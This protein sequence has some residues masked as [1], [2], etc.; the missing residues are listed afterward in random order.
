MALMALR[1]CR[2]SLEAVLLGF[3]VC[4]SPSA[5]ATAKDQE[6]ESWSLSFLTN[7]D[8]QK[9]VM[10]SSETWLVTY[11]DGGNSQSQAMTNIL[12]GLA[13]KH[14]NLGINLGMVDCAEETKLCRTAGIRE[15]IPVIHLLMGDPT[16]N[17]YTRKSYR[18]PIPFVGTQFDVRSLERFFSKNYPV[19]LVTTINSTAEFDAYLANNTAPSPL[20]S[21]PVAVL[22][23]E[24]DAVGMLIRT[25]SHHFRVRIKF[26]QLRI[27]K[28][29]DVASRYGVEETTLGVLTAGEL[30]GGGSSSY[31]K[32]VK[33]DG[34]SL[35]SR[36]AILAFLKP[37][38][39]APVSSNE[40]QGDNSFDASSSTDSE[41]SQGYSEDADDDVVKY[42]AT[43][44]DLTILS[45]DSAYLIAVVS[46]A[47]NTTTEI[48]DWAK[49][50]KSAEG[51]IKA[52]ILECADYI[53][54]ESTE[55]GKLGQKACSQY[56]ASRPYVLVVPYGS[57]LRKKKLDTSTSKWASGLQFNPEDCSKAKAAAGDSLPDTS[58][59]S[60]SEQFFSQF[61]Q[62]GMMKDTSS[63]IYL[64]RS[65]STLPPLIK[66]IALTYSDIA[67]FG[68][69]VNPSP[70]FM[71]S[72]GNPKLPTLMAVP[73]IDPTDPEAAKEGL[74]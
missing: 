53:S 42:S 44:L 64:S 47:A 32:L 7:A 68:F 52:A 66:N 16:I 31:S 29:P 57:T 5:A 36:E 58:I 69:L 21:P 72:I 73:T 70:E 14:S 39:T 65:S 60:L 10:D 37:Y 38:D 9:K 20:I 67:Q 27:D 48:P 13:K 63:V 40:A 19:S 1:L 17:P 28:V 46:S 49:L 15:M 41:Q 3:I 55:T 2:R 43:S 12:D 24:K 23:T 45:S 18:I 61:V 71:S 6:G 26:L 8:F 59:R 56:T 62:E 33:F 35:K 34:D 30:E 4:S 11:Y 54:T 25:V 50:A 22:F 51:K 74:K